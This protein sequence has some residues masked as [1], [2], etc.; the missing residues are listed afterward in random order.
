[1]RVV[2]RTSCQGFHDSD[3]AGGSEGKGADG[4]IALHPVG[5]EALIAELAQ[6]VQEPAPPLPGFLFAVDHCFPIKGQGTVLTGTVISGACAFDGL[7]AASPVMQ[8]SIVPYTPY[9]HVSK[10]MLHLHHQAPSR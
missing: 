9:P 2:C 4:D 3:E 1:V 6:R 8:L 10:F 5:L 7:R